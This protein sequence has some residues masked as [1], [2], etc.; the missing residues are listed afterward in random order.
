[1]EVVHAYD[2]YNELMPAFRK[3]RILSR[4]GD[5]ALVYM[6]VGVARNTVTLW[7]QVRILSRAN[8]DRSRTVE[9]TMMRG[10]MSHFRAR[11]VLTPVDG[12]RR[13]RVEFRILV[14]PEMPLPSSIFT[15]ENVK[16]ARRM[17][18]AIRN[19]FASA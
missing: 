2:H 12:G 10:N 18:I 9:A 13:T 19:R 8:D 6:E 7:G 5:D 16:A 17:V 3:A 4:R 1:L 15:E 11:W 14:D